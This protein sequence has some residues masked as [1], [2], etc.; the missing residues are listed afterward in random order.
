M[1]P[2]DWNGISPRFINSGYGIL[3]GAGDFDLVEENFIR[4]KDNVE[5]GSGEVEGEGD[6]AEVVVYKP[7]TYEDIS[8]EEY[9]S[10]IMKYQKANGLEMTGMVDSYTKEFME[11][12]R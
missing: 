6:S 8:H 7:L 3:S 9:Q 5:V 12:P 4:D 2:A 10:A 1:K 11:K